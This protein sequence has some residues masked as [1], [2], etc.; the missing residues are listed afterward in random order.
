MSG[1]DAHPLP[2]QDGKL[3]AAAYEKIMEKLRGC[4][5]ALIGPGLGR[6]GESD[7]LLAAWLLKFN[8]PFFWMPMA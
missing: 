6:S 1:R 7:A 8:S 2:E 4:D 3:S 5:A